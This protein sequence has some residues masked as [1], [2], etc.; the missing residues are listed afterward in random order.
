VQPE[1]GEKLPED[2]GGEVEPEGKE[3]QPEDPVAQAKAAAEALAAEKEKLAAEL[4]TKDQELEAFRAS[5]AKAQEAERT[6][7]EL[8][9]ALGPEL[10]A[11]DEKVLAGEL[12]PDE[13][14]DEGERLAAR[15]LDN[16]QKTSELER[17]KAELAALKAEKT[18][19]ERVAAAQ[20]LITESPE[21][22]VGGEA[23]QK[24]VLDA[25]LSGGDPVAAVEKVA[26]LVA[27]VAG[28]AVLA[29]KERDA[30]AGKAGPNVRGGAPAAGSGGE[31]RPLTL[32]EKLD[33]A[34]GSAGSF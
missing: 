25:V 23:A 17:T 13:A 12:T 19:S 32:A 5:Q 31:S 29:Q 14:A 16:Y 21:M 1:G 8:L 20:K 7:T 10:D 11:L 9:K 30:A 22:K 6:K 34:F 26:G 27:A 4:A 15:W 3:V 33:R 24:M 18:N 28:A 2:P